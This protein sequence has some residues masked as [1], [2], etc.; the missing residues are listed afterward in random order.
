MKFSIVFE[1]NE[2]KAVSLPKK[3]ITGL[4]AWDEIRKF[5]REYG[6]EAVRYS[7]EIMAWENNIKVE[8]NEPFARATGRFSVENEIVVRVP[9]GALNGFVYERICF[10]SG[11]ALQN[12]VRCWVTRKL[13]ENNLLESWKL[14]GYPL[15]WDVEGDDVD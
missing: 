13:N 15:V 4:D 5:V 7:S 1:S 8:V 12:Q 6:L 3:T 14:A 9:D 11:E 10:C 2:I